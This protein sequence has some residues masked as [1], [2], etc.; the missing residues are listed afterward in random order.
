[1]DLLKQSPQGVIDLNLASETLNVQKRRIYDI[2]NVLEG[3]GLLEKKSKNN[4]QWK[5]GV[6][7]SAYNRKL[8]EMKR[9]EQK[10][11]N[12]NNLLRTVQE[13]LNKVS[14]KCGYITKQDL[15]SI[16]LFRNQSVIVI[17]APPDAKLV[18]SISGGQCQQLFV[19]IMAFPF[20]PLQLP[21]KPGFEL[22]LRS[23]KG[24]I[25]V[26]FTDTSIENLS[27]QQSSSMSSKGSLFSTG[28][29]FTD[30]L[31]GDIKPLLSSSKLIINFIVF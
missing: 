4:I 12:L 8:A 21:E 2:T 16:P 20:I 25:G 30:S 6:D 19:S 26:F 29:I 11:N 28:S 31:M 1:M 15:A 7:D 9:L 10:E 22:M 14:N 27:Q 17:K 23:G 18:V 3:V 24:E 13:D 5:F